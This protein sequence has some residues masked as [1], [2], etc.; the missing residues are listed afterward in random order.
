MRVQDAMT[1]N[2]AACAPGTNL[3]AAAEL[4]WKNDCGSLP[5]VDDSGKAIGIV[6]D[7]D[8][9]IALGTR[10]G[11]PSE[12]TVAEVMTSPVF[13][14]RPSDPID[15]ALAKMNARK[16]RRLAVA[17]E[18][19]KLAG[20]LTMNDVVRHA[21]RKPAGRD[22]AVAYDDVM[23]ALKGICDHSQAARLTATAA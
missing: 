19:G 12:M 17:T 9:L 16:I 10:N 20:M 23:T 7:R 6:T 4:M 13:T 11:R 5:V 18:D 21:D 8:M 22:A 2:P 3:A 1:R 15:T 14:C